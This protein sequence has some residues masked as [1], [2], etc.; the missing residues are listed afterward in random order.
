MADSHAFD[1]DFPTPPW[2]TDYDR[3]HMITY[4]SLLRAERNGTDWREAAKTL[5]ALDVDADEAKARTIWQAHID[6]ARWFWVG[7][8]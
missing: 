8:A 3:V 4:V 6:R 2:P 7:D 1:S 5:L